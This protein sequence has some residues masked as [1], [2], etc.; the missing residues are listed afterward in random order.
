MENI[1]QVKDKKFKPFISEETIQ[2]EVARIAA[3][4]NRELAQKDPIFLG[5]LKY[6]V[7]TNKGV[8]G[9]YCCCWFYYA[10][11]MGFNQLRYFECI[12]G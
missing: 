10:V 8:L 4:M 1:V 9:T 7:L 11:V 12:N 2:T 3:Q 6:I 5:I